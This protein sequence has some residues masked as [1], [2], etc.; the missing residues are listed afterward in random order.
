LIK[1]YDNN[2][3]KL[4]DVKNDIGESFD[5]SKIYMNEKLTIKLEKILDKYLEEVEA[6][7]WQ[8]GITWK[9][10]TL[11]IINSYH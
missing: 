4:Y 8:P 9:E 11:K 5:L 10:N 7:K 1:F 3:I 2:D 6:P